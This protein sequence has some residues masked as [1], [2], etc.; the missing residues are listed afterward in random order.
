MQTLGVV[1]SMNFHF[2]QRRPW[3]Y[4]ML[5]N[6]L[7]VYPCPGTI[8]SRFKGERRQTTPYITTPELLAIRCLIC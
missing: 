3:R 4:R 1:V 7:C 8:H 6:E 2:D 5:E